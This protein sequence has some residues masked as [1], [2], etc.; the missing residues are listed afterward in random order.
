MDVGSEVVTG[1]EYDLHGEVYPLT[2]RL[3]SRQKMRSCLLCH[4]SFL[5][6]SSGH[7]YCTWCKNYL[8]NLGEDED[9]HEVNARPI[10][11]G[12]VNLP[13]SVFLDREGGSEPS[14]DLSA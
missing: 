12:R 4:Q 3:Q 9:P 14:A 2:K 10:V 11:R 6:A 7:R 1:V 13:S 5:S 8:H